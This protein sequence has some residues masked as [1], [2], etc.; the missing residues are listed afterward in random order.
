[1]ERYNS[2]VQKINALW[3]KI[4]AKFCENECF[5]TMPNQAV[6]AAVIFTLEI[7]AAAGYNRISVGVHWFDQL[8]DAKA[9]KRKLTHRT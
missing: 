6:I 7:A 4:K 8:V 2:L 3:L 9:E 5:E 1:M